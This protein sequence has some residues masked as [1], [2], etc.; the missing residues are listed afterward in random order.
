MNSPFRQIRRVF[1]VAPPAGVTGQ[2]AGNSPR[3]RGSTSTK[4]YGVAA[5]LRRIPIE[6]RIVIQLSVIAVILYVSGIAGPLCTVGIASILVLGGEHIDPISFSV[7]VLAITLVFYLAGRTPGTI[8]SLYQR[9][10]GWVQ[11]RSRSRG[12]A[13]LFI[14][15][16]AMACCVARSL[17]HGVPVP[18][19][20]DEFN[21]LLLADT[22]CSGRVTNPTHPM[23]EHFESIHVIHQPTYTSKFP[24]AQGIAL[25]LGRFVA[26]H[27]VVGL[28]ISVG[29]MAAAI[30]WMLFAWLPA[31]WAFLTSLI[32]ALHIGMSYWAYSYWGGAV[33]AAAGALVMGGFRRIVDQPRKRD[34]I[35]LGLGL[36]TLAISRP[37]E[38]LLASLPVAVVL[39]TW[40]ITKHRSY[41]RESVGK[42]VIPVVLILAVAGTAMMYYNQRVTGSPFRLPY[43]LHID[44]YTSAPPF[45]WQS[46]Q[47]PP[48]YRHEVL[49][50]FH[51]GWEIKSYLPQRSLSGFILR[52][53]YKCTIMWQFYAGPVFTLLLLG[54]PWLL[55]DR[56][57]RFALGACA[58]LALGILVETY[59]YPHYL[60]PI[61]C[62]FYA[63]YG[64][65]MYFWCNGHRRWRGVGRTIVIAVVVA[66][67]ASAVTTFAAQPYA[68]FMQPKNWRF[69]RERIR[70]QLEDVGGR[71]LIMVRYA[72]SHSP[73]EDWMS[74]AADI[75]AAQ[76]VWAHEMDVESNRKLLN[77]F[78]DRQVWL[79]EPDRLPPQVVPYVLESLQQKKVSP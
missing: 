78:H 19:C 52:L 7:Q 35:L 75:D 46:L 1:G 49:E 77:Y 58:L 68:P 12:R 6:I 8:A 59:C 13:I 14:G 51:L 55:A 43:K 4:S 3:L 18:W 41:W 22:F 54:I 27:A 65:A 5:S 28:W 16:L 64:C 48:Q 17:V 32:A 56:W 61:T 23:W 79:L 71:H 29:L 34:A 25:A 66:S 42:I 39:G 31:R 69:D 45:L 33:A 63:C 24:P 9:L 74:N 10:M 11:R 2:K 40:M 20:T 21:Y 67:F 30:C 73:H 37:F 57:M 62:L 60:A 26:G 47:P 53:V 50:R 38:G 72:A 76:V 70:A 15:L 44:T 36:V